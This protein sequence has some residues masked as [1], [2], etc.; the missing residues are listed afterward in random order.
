MVHRVGVPLAASSLLPWSR[1]VTPLHSIRAR[2]HFDA[3]FFV[4]AVPPGQEPVHDQ[5]ETTESI[6]LAPEAALKE[7]WE[8]HIELAAPQIMS[9]AQLARFAAVADVLS[10]ANG[11][12]PPRIQPEVFQDG[13]V[14]IVCYPGDPRHSVSMRLLPGP[15]RLCWRNDRYEPEGGL[16]ALLG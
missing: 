15:T 14:N 8:G 11:C 1:W 16:D 7:Y 13:G 9:L 4:A 12:K 2:K 3:R 10:Q 6:W 5:Y